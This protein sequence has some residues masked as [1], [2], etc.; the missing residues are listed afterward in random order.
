M[1]TVTPFC[2]VIPNDVTKVSLLFVFDWDVI[3]KMYA[4][5]GFKGTPQGNLKVEETAGTDT[6]SQ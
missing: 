2:R 4:K 5:K 6:C 1:E 3:L